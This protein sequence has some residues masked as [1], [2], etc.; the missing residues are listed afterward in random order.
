MMSIKVLVIYLSMLWDG[1]RYLNKITIGMS[2]LNW[3]KII[4]AVT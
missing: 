3:T 1:N 2:T 4:G